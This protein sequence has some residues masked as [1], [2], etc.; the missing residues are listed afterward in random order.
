MGEQA[1][2]EHERAQM[3]DPEGLLASLRGLL[4]VGPHPAG[5]VDQHVESIPPGEHLVGTR[6]DGAQ[7]AQIEHRDVHIVV[8][9]S[10]AHLRRGGLSLLQVAASQHRGH[11]ESRH[12]DGRLPCRYRR[13]SR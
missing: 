2:G 13:S 3:V 5:I 11:A 9:R 10:R 7:V 12:A 6:V 1:M 4:P 8:A